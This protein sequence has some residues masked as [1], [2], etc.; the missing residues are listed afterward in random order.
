[1]K[2]LSF[3]FGIIAGLIIILTGMLTALKLTPPITLQGL[4]ITLGIW[5]IFAGTVILGLVFISQK[6]Y[7]KLMSSGIILMGLFEILVFYFEKDYSIL[8][9]GP[10]IAILAGILRLSD[11]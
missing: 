1:M 4:E 9:I 2:R 10:F 5:R 6:M 8:F 11:K 7:P 3:Y